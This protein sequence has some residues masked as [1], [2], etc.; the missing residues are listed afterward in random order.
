VVSA[1]KVV[2][3]L[4]KDLNSCMSGVENKIE[5]DVMKMEKTRVESF[6]YRAMKYSSRDGK[7]L[8]I[9]A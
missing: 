5:S 9:T 6:I 4:V 7:V 3:V 8:A 2:S 1:C